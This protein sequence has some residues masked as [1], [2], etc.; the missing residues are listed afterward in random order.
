MG[1]GSV[2]VLVLLVFVGFISGWVGW[3]PRHGLLRAIAMASAVHIPIIDAH[4]QV[5]FA[6]EELDKVIRLMDKGGVARTILSSRGPVTAKQLVSFASK[7]PGRIIP[8]VRTKHRFYRENDERFDTFLQKQVNIPQFG[9]MAEVLM[10]HAQKGLRRV[11]APQVIVYP[12]DERVRVALKYAMKKKW[13]FVVHIEFRRAGSLRDEF[14]KK[15]EALLISYQKH[16]FIL[17]HMG[18]LDHVDVRKLIEAHDNISFITAHSTSIQ[19]SPIAVVKKSED[20]RT[21]MFDGDHLAA[22][23]KELMLKHL[24][25]FILGFDNVWPE[26]WSQYYLDQIKLWRGAIKDL[27]PEV[28]HA[29]TH[30]NA[31]RLW[32]LPRLK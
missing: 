10:Y 16:P 28:A 11:R 21:N 12:D 30:G 25:R 23:W 1:K 32:R 31:E 3:K 4:S 19:A 27:P 7:Y 22:D 9:A 26:H 17:I 6:Y 14:M 15:L 24:D 8:A 29:F 2:R 13:P 18:Q 20:P 5:P